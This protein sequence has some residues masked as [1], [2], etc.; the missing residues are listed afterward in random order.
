MFL[1]G[2]ERRLVD[3]DAAI[4]PHVGR[5][6]VVAELVLGDALLQHPAPEHVVDDAPVRRV[7]LLA[8]LHQV[9]AQAPG[10]L[11]DG[12]GRPS[13]TAAGGGGL[14][15]VN[16]IGEPPLQLVGG[17]AEAAVGLGGVDG[18]DDGPTPRISRRPTTGK[19]AVEALQLAVHR[20]SG[21]GSWGAWRSSQKRVRNRAKRRFRCRRGVH[22]QQSKAVRRK[23]DIIT[24]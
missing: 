22:S 5:H 6:D 23:R 8:V 20:R 18:A 14:P 12:L 15:N 16:V 24:A 2:L 21:R 10:Q 4:V 9:V 1:Q 17:G 19:G 11:V 3:D 7:E 13:Q